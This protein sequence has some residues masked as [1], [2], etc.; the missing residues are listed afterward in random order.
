[1]HCQCCE[2]NL[3]PINLAQTK[4]LLLQ[5]RL[6]EPSLKFKNQLIS[7]VTRRRGEEKKSGRR[8]LKL[9]ATKKTVLHH[10]F[11]FLKM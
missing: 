6:S 4:I 10:M 7:T 3:A 9:K 5:R 8:R 2:S 1:V 11:A